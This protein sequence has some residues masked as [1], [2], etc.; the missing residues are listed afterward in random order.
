MQPCGH[1]QVYAAAQALILHGGIGAARSLSPAV[2]ECA[3]REL[4][5]QAPASAPT[6]APGGH[7]CID[8]AWQ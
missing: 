3:L 5:D 6:S 4:Y 8:I 1:V 2:L 7:F